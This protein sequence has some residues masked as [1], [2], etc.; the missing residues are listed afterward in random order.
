MIYIFSLMKGK[1]D[2]VKTRSGNYAKCQVRTT[3]HTKKNFPETIPEKLI[4]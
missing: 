4:L 3:N 2:K 1:D